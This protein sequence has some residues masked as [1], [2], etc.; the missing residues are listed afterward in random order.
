MEDDTELVD[1][2]GIKVPKAFKERWD[3]LI[4]KNKELKNQLF[5][6]K[7]SLQEK[8][9][10]ANPELEKAQAR[11]AELEGVV[12]KSEHSRT[13]AADGVD[14][15]EDLYEYLQYQYG[16]VTPEEGKEKPAF[17]DWYK[18]AKT[19]SS[20]IKAAVE[21]AASAKA[22]PPE[23]VKPGAKPTAGAKPGTAPAP[24]KKTVVST[25]TVPEKKPSSSE[26][27]VDAEAISSMDTATWKANKAN[28]RKQLFGS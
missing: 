23:G 26:V 2:G 11:I 16:K 25:K 10:A 13:L 21:A 9:T 3:E 8:E 18:D 15:D 6:A 7:T 27:G 4:G 14:G 19:K 20:V 1:L 5:E 28:I 12:A 22:Q 24:E 17:G